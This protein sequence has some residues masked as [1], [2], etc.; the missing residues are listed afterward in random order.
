MSKDGAPISVDM[1]PPPPGHPRLYSF[2][3]TSTF[4]VT[5][6]TFYAI[7]L[8]P[9]ED[10]TLS[11][12]N[13]MRRNSTTDPGLVVDKVIMW[14]VNDTSADAGSNGT[15]TNGTQTNGTQNDSGSAGSNG[16]SNSVPIGAVVGASVS[17]PV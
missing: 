17:K 3:G 1:S 10:Y 5:P 16:H 9:E 12:V 13:D 4:R 15:Q 11:I 14:K 2:T 6:T 7:A 8:D